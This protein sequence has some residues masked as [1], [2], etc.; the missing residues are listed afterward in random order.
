MTQKISLSKTPFNI[1]TFT[2]KKN[3]GFSLVAAILAVMVS[4]VYLYTVITNYVETYDKLIYSYDNLFLTFAAIMAIAA[5][6][7]LMVL[8]YINFSYLYN[9][10]ASDYFHALPLKRSELLFARFSGSYV[11]ALIPL[12]LGYL[13]TYALS[14]LDYVAADRGA[15]VEAYFFTVIMMAVLGLF[16]LL[17]IVTAG[18]V[19]DS[20]L[21]LLAVNIG[22]P[23]IVAFVY[24]LCET[25]L[26]GFTYSGDYDT[27]ILSHT[28]PFGYAIVKLCM[29]IY[30][31]ETPLFSAISVFAIIDMLALFGA[32]NVI[33][34]NRRKSE[35]LGGS[36]AFKFISEIIGFIIASLGLFVMG[37]I[38]G[39]NPSEIPYWIAGVVG[40]CIAAVVYSLIINRGFKKVKKAVIVGLIASVVLIITNFGIKL[41]LFGWEKNLP[42]TDEIESVQIEFAGNIIDVQNIDLAVEF[43]K[44]IVEEHT[45]NPLDRSNRFT[46]DY[47]LKNGKT[48]RRRYEVETEIAKDLKARL[49]GEE[50]SRQILEDFAEFKEKN[51][52]AWELNGY[53]Y[54]DGKYLGRFDT[55]VSKEKAEELV[56]A[57]AED[58]KTYGNKYFVNHT[59][60]ADSSLHIYGKVVV[61]VE[62]EIM[63]DGSIR[64]YTDYKDFSIAVENY[65]TFKN[66]I[67]VLDTI[68]YELDTSNAE[69]Y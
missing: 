29:G 48:V 30:D 61:K 26:Y 34:Y 50:Y 11:A 59:T 57:Y 36:Y 24:G 58:L 66:V 42:K 45:E 16:T 12:T 10:S 17:F 13:G 1:F 25:H 3:L 46:F 19:F 27:N 15:I 51:V 4:P 56:N 44:T 32:L 38:F 8:L 7:F 31:A 52:E 14:F 47:V 22:I 18:G 55:T 67:S 28:T 5:T 35:K 33:F 62:T 40:A 23:I 49:I 37:Y 54:E 64:E 9:K 53:V 63:E 6:A 20:I 43:N 39:D 60:Y 41:D 21:S 68:E 69:K 65:E 2:L